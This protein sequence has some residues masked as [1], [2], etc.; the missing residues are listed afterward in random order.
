MTMQFAESTADDAG[1][2]LALYPL[3]FPDEDLTGL[4]KALLPHPDI[5]SLVG[6]KDGAIV[7]NAICSICRSTDGDEKLA[8]LGPIAV[9][10]DH[11]G[12][13]IGTALMA[14][15]ADRLKA[16]GMREILVM[17]D[18]D[19]YRPRG[20]DQKAR[21]EPPFP[22]NREWAE[23][24]RSMA[25]TDAPRATGRLLAPEPWMKPEYWA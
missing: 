23:A 2:I 17:G 5:L 11:Q 25:L 12:G 13:G 20:F 3:A 19:Y 9:H 22:L 15:A 8:L 14:H 4:V 16:A 24:W 7:A 21:V 18:P 6:V 10:P 1:A